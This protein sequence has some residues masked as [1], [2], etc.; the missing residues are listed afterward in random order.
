MEK[1]IGIN[2]RKIRELKGL[3]QEYMASQLSLSQRAYSK[4]ESGKHVCIGIA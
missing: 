4:L 2:I 1:A 3:S